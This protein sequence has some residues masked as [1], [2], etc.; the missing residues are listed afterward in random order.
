MERPPEGHRFCRWI[1]AEKAVRCGFGRVA[2]R[3]AARCAA[4]PLFIDLRRF[5]TYTE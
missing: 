1:V 3:A 2:D 5:V 4:A